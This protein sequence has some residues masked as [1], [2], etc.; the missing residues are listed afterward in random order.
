MT[1][2]AHDG[3][4]RITVYS[5]HVLHPPTSLTLTP[6]LSRLALSWI[7]QGLY[8]GDAHYVHPA[9]LECLA[10]A[11]HSSDCQHQDEL[12]HLS[13]PVNDEDGYPG[14]R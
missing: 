13:N 1:N 7:E 11:P 6:P 5:T 9:T 14:S 8:I 2:F 3:H 4:S 10:A 12:E